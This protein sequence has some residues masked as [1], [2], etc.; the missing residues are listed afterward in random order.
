MLIGGAKVDSSNGACIEVVNPYT[1]ETIDA[2]PNASKGDIEKSIKAAHEGK[3]LW[4]RTPLHERAKVLTNSCHIER[5]ESG[6][7]DA[8]V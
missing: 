2:V 6:A 7:C 8:P 4:A 1:L 5:K 3:R